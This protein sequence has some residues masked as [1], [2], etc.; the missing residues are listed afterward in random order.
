MAENNNINNEEVKN[1]EEN[2]VKKT[3]ESKSEVSVAK[4]KSKAK[5][6]PKKTKKQKALYRKIVIIGII[7]AVIACAVAYT[8]FKISE[9]PEVSVTTLEQ[10]LEQMSDL[11][12]AKLTYCGI[13]RYSKGVSLINKTSFNMLYEA[14]ITAGIDVKDIKFEVTDSKVIITYPK[15]K[16]LSSHINEDSLQFYDQNFALFKTDQKDIMK[17]TMKKAKEELKGKRQYKN[18]MSTANRQTES[19]LKM[20][21]SKAIG[22]RKLVIKS[23]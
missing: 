18:L 15:A 23:R 20:L 1:P 21:Y 8:A 16:I 11:T 4:S 9:K 3:S 10:S 12:T 13:V 19:L 7:L 22:D 6:K 14:E 2:S 17:D 5:S